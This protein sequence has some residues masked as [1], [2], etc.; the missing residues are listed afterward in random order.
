M[1][2]R[3]YNF[4]HNRASIRASSFWSVHSAFFLDYILLHLLSST[5]TYQHICVLEDSYAAHVTIF[6]PFVMIRFFCSFIS[7]TFLHSLLWFVLI[8]PVA[9]YIIFCLFGVSVSFF[10][11][12]FLGRDDFYP[13]N[14]RWSNE[15]ISSQMRTIYL[16]KSRFLVIFFFKKKG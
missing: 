5:H 13:G 16:G 10:P 4:I 3:T 1:Y 6:F 14:F 11:A 8:F 9:G 7:C 15:L 2:V 12:R